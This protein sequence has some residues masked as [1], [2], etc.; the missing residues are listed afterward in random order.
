MIWQE[1]SNLNGKYENLK[2][3][4]H[5]YDNSKE[6]GLDFRIGLEKFEFVVKY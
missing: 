6:D 4:F 1:L 2:K 5:I 3:C